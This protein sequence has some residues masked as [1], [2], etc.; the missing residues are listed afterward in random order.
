M[1]SI[2]DSD[3]GETSAADDLEMR[4]R[5]LNSL[6]V[7]IQSLTKRTQTMERESDEFAN[8]IQELQ[9][10]LERVQAQQTE[11]SRNISRQQKNTERYIAKRQMLANRKDECS[12]NIRDLGVLPEE[13]FE[14]YTSEK[15]DR[16]GVR[17][18]L[19][20]RELTPI[21]SARQE[22]PYSQR[23]SQEI[24]ACQQEGIRTVQQFHETEGPAVRAK[25]R[26]R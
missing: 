7:S 8:R 20:H 12:R 1:E 16:V 9:R 21:S 22:A 15:L 26:F 18:F 19:V 24:C 2:Q 14:K 25:R 5:E 23:R 4:K 17:V 3:G 10:S 11:D 13:A 6:N